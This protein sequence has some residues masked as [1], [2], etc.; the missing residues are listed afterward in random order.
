VL[1]TLA[2]ATLLAANSVNPPAIFAIEVIE[3][4]ILVILLK[5]R[6]KYC[7]YL[8][9]TCLAAAPWHCKCI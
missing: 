1:E 2:I 7:K 4:F 5:F 8:F 3:V 9:A 6:K